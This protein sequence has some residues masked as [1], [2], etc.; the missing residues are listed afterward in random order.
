MRLS[1]E[2]S[3]AQYDQYLFACRV[4]G[5][6]GNGEAVTKYEVLFRMDQDDTGEWLERE[7]NVLAGFPVEIFD[8]DTR[9][10][11]QSFVQVYRLS[12]TNAARLE[13]V[14]DGSPDVLSYREVL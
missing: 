4:A 1:R 10:S 7:N 3:D 11:G 14:L 9:P 13:Q 5:E 6:K 2:E 12:T 8:V